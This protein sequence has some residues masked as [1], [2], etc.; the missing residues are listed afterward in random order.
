MGIKELSLSEMVRTR[1]GK[2]SKTSN[3]ILFYS[4]FGN[5][6]IKKQAQRQVFWLKSGQATEQRFLR[7]RQDSRQD[8]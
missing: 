2:G 4:G 7:Q 3:K 6:S 1:M 8:L 5:L